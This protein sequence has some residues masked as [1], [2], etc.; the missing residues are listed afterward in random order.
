MSTLEERFNKLTVTYKNEDGEDFAQEPLG[1][2]DEQEEV[3]LAFIEAEKELSHGEG[4]N[5]RYNIPMGVS[6]WK[7][8][9]E[10]YGYFK[11]FQ[12]HAFEAGRQKGFKENHTILDQNFKEFLVSGSSQSEEVLQQV[13]EASKLQAYKEIAEMVEKEQEEI[14]TYTYS[15]R[16]AK[17]LPKGFEDQLQVNDAIEWGVVEMRILQKILDRL[18]PPKT[19]TKE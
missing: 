19:E 14:R 13:R 16:D 6:Q 15:L 12:P 18:T 3:V 8:H 1:L 9:G 5:T 4:I 11:Y 17:E 7:Q 2:N 10:K